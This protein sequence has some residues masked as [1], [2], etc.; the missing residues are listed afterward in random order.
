MNLEHVFPIPI[1]RGEIDPAIIEDTTEK[2]NKFLQDTKFTEPAVP[3]QLLTT[4]Y[5]NK[6]FLG[7][8]R[9]IDLLHAIDKH[10]RDFFV[11][12]G[13][14]PVCFIE[15]TSWLQYNQPGS[16]FNRHDHYGALTSGCIYIQTPENGGEIMF[17]NPLE[18][19]RCTNTFFSRL[20]KEENDYNFS[21]VRYTPKRGDII[22]FE[23][24]LQH[25]VRRNN[26]NEPRIS[27]GFNI[28]ADKDARG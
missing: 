19:R 18:Q 12:L 2:V 23:S 27:I 28:W 6:N 1:I 14:D 3:N 9:A 15:I 11:L 8:I 21:H 7:N 24:W 17:H 26:S 4:F 5:D 22:M 13:F 25:T 16:D 10:T 20:Q